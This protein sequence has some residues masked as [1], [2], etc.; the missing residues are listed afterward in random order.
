M[1]EMQVQSLGHE[2]TLEEG[3][4]T[5]SSIL[6]WR[7]PWTEEPGRLQS[8]WSHRVRYNWR[9]SMHALELLL[10]ATLYRFRFRLLWPRKTRS[11]FSRNLSS[12]KGVHK[13]VLSSTPQT[14]G[15]GCL[16]VSSYCVF[17]LDSRVEK[18]KGDFFR[19]PHSTVLTYHWLK[20]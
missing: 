7:I 16:F 14:H 13:P 10:E 19:N 1:Q 20:A 4:A 3:M 18:E 15:P 6:A 11:L 12:N 5:H 17:I 2:D 9:D 8:I